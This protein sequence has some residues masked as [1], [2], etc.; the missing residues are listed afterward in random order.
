MTYKPFAIA[1]FG[2]YKRTELCDDHS[3]SNGMLTNKRV[4]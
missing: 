3:K 1:V 2:S 4:I